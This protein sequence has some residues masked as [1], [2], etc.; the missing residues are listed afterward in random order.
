MY[1]FYTSSASLTSS[2]AAPSLALINKLKPMVIH[3]Q[4]LSTS[5]PAS[6]NSKS[7]ITDESNLLFSPSL[8]FSVLSPS[9]KHGKEVSLG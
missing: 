9:S 3:I 7:N 5:S 4:S 2:S 8:Y 1:R 6:Y